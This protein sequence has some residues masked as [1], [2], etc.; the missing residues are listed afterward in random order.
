MKAVLFLI[1]ILFLFSVFA[2]AQI[3]QPTPP[4]TQSDDIVKITTDLVQVDAVITDKDGN[5]VTNLTADD[6]DIFQD[7]K[8]QKITNFSYVNREAQKTTPV[9]ANKKPG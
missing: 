5:Q 4:E 9:I 2:S 8:P 3:T 1:A 6:V 7:G